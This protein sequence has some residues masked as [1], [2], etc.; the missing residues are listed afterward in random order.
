LETTMPPRSCLLQSEAG[1][2]RI[3]CNRPPTMV[4]NRGERSAPGARGRAG[5]TRNSVMRQ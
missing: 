3:K 1:Y 5:A 2:P 4:R